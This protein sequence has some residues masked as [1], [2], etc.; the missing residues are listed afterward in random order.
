MFSVE[1][2][3]IVL[4]IKANNSEIARITSLK[5]AVCDI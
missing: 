3:G 5:L 1:M 4:N 2:R